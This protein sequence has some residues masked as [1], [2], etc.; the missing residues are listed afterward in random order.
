MVDRIAGT[1]FLPFHVWCRCTFEIIVEDWDKWID[2]YVEKHG[3]EN[4]Q[5]VEDKLY[6]EKQ[7]EKNCQQELVQTK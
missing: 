2:D 6:D 5:N 3:K 7:Y 4:A 1:N